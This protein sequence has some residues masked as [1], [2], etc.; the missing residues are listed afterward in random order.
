MRELRVDLLEVAKLI[1]DDGFQGRHALIL[2]GEPCHHDWFHTPWV[3]DDGY[4]LVGEPTIARAMAH[5]KTHLHCRVV[6]PYSDEAV[7]AARALDVNLG[8]SIQLHALVRVVTQDVTLHEPPFKGVTKPWREVVRRIAKW[9]DMAAE[10]LRKVVLREVKRQELG[11]APKAAKPAKDEWK[12]ECYGFECHE[13]VLASATAARQHFMAASAAITRAVAELGGVEPELV[14]LH[15]RSMRETFRQMSAEL[16]LGAPHALCPWCKSTERAR[17]QCL[18][19]ERLGWV[20]HHIYTRAPVE[21]LKN[22]WVAYA[23]ELLDARTMR[24]PREAEERVA[25]F[26]EAESY[27][28]EEVF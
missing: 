1:V 13:A 21:L 25:D 18:A 22:Y 9:L 10:A 28:E 27:E 5:G 3:T 23:G 15:L 24:H 14:P 7:A 8:H 17:P 26:G 2:R 16:R 4:V 6:K 20:P 19:C 11:K 12:L